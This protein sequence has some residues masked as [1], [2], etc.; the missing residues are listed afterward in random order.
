MSWNEIFL[1]R[2]LS[3]EMIVDAVGRLFDVNPQLI[4]VTRDDQWQPH[5]TD[6]SMYLVCDLTALSPDFPL[7]LQIVISRENVPRATPFNP[8]SVGMLCELLGC[9]ALTETEAN[10]Y[11]PYTFTL[12]RGRHDYQRVLVSAHHLD[13]NNAFVIEQYL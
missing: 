2:K 5:V 6:A 9:E 8:E 10:D 13:N 1:S 7:R 11:D 4:R 3:P 12:V